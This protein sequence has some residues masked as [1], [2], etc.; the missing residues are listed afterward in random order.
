MPAKLV[1]EEGHQKGLSLSIDEGD[2]WIIGSDPSAC[3]L[4]LEEAQISDRHL[5]LKRTPEGIIVE[6]LATDLPLLINDEELANS[7]YLLQS[8]DTIK[9]GDE[10][11]R[12]YEESSNLNQD[13]PANIEEA[14][15]PT[16]EENR[17]SQTENFEEEHPQDTIFSDD[18]DYS[19]ILAEIDFGIVET[20]RWLLKVVG[21]PN[22]GAEFYMQAGNSYLVGTDPQ[23]CDIIFH[24]TSVSRQ[25]ARITVTPEDTLLIEDINS[26]NGILINGTLI[27]NSQE[28][29]PSTIVTVGTTSFVVYDREG[30]MQTIISPLLPSIVKGL[31][32]A[33]PEGE[34]SAEP[35]ETADPLPSEGE[36]IEEGEHLRQD[37]PQPPTPAAGSSLG[38]YVVISVIAALFLI[39]GIGTLT[40]F[41]DKPIAVQVQED[42]DELI[43][44]ILKPF[45]SIHWTF[46]KSNGSLLL[47]GHVMTMAEKNRITYRLSD[48][49]FIKSLDDTGIIID[50]GVLNEVN[51]LLLSNP[52]WKGIRVYSPEAGQF[53]LSGT[54]KNRRLADQLFNYISLNFPYLDGLKKQIIIEEDIVQQAQSWLTGA[55]LT[56]ITVEI[57]NGEIIVAGNYPNEKS[58][59]FSDLIDKIEQLP[60]VR[61]VK[62]Q[63]SP[64]TIET[65]IIDITD[66]YAV[67]GTSRVNKRYTVV[68]NGRILSE[69]DDLNGMTID[70]V[71][72][73]SIELHRGN[74]RFRI[75]Y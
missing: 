57:K 48:L 29:T 50:E 4:V 60:G 24:D 69:G 41:Q 75:S 65:G 37:E 43:E 23:T 52:E 72:P 26:R 38:S 34:N 32:Q 21:G 64:R 8:G 17:E 42:G 11:L 6:N 70:R 66:Q 20:G 15:L 73:N 67:T 71:S 33:P 10:T 18:S 7:T 54:L 74:D 28:L 1:V 61:S 5:H 44:E 53:I 22:S 63:T 51:S 58:T 40:L 35:S 47:L 12:F 36:R 39:A 9:I 45:P 3:Q 46:N 55:N 49:K 30:E 31:H 27:Q 2:S 25:H 56:D 19:Q 14:P 59:I 13:T 68:I 62:N 16:P